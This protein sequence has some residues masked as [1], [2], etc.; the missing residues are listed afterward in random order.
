MVTRRVITG[1][2]TLRM[3]HRPTTQTSITRTGIRNRTLL[4]DPPTHGPTRLIVM[5]NRGTGG[6]IV[7]AG[8]GSEFDCVS[9]KKV[10]S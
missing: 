5:T 8:R 3:V 2:N 6:G 4:I 7:A 10:V 1:P 9:R